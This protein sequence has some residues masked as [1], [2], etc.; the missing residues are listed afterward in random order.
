M[1]CGFRLAVLATVPG[2]EVAAEV[3]DHGPSFL[4]GRSR[5]SRAHPKQVV[6]ADVESVRTTTTVAV[7]HCRV[8]SAS[9]LLPRTITVREAQVP[10]GLDGPEI[11]LR[12]TLKV[13]PLAR[14]E[15]LVPPGS[16]DEDEASQIRRNRTLN[17][18]GR[19]RSEASRGIGAGGS[20][21]AD[22]TDERRTVFHLERTPDGLALRRRVDDDPLLSRSGR[23]SEN[24]KSGG[25]DGQNHAVHD[26]VS[27]IQVEMTIWP[28]LEEIPLYILYTYF[29]PFVK[30]LPHESLKKQVYLCYSRH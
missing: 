8:V 17:A 5:A 21:S 27:E 1:M 29:S 19:R 22:H 20:R 11:G 9:D 6:G 12:P 7:T 24:G 15:H 18:R 14:E 30:Y 2:F 4:L 25:H 23:S 3:A 26:V 28:E 13:D 16:R 10:R